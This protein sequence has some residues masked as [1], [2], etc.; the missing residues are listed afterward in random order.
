MSYRKTSFYIESVHSNK[1]LDV[2]DASEE[3][4]AEVVLHDFNGNNNQQWKY[5]NGMIYSKLN[6][7]VMDIANSD[8][9]GKVIMWNPHGGDNQ[10]WTFERDFTIRSGLGT[11]MDV[12]AANTDNYTNIIGLPKNGGDNQKFRIVPVNKD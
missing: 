3:Q 4:G 1:Y 2:K 12:Q 7:L 9:G 8:K 11:V 5:K 10:Q 6:G